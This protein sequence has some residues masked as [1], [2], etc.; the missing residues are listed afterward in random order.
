MHVPEAALSEPI[1]TGASPQAKSWPGHA[2]APHRFFLARRVT[3]AD[4]PLTA[5]R[6][7][8]G[9][10]TDLSHLPS[11]TTK[12]RL[13][14]EGGWEQL[15]GGRPGARHSPPLLQLGKELKRH[16]NKSQSIKF[17]EGN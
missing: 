2:K 3:G 11:A 15:A 7:E 5:P 13:W 16:G 9:E 1:H 4:S 8:T 14:K 12:T 17:I 6:L 10:A